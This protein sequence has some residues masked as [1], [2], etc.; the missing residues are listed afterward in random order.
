MEIWLNDK[1]KELKEFTR[2]V[3]LEKILPKRRYYDENEEFPW[4]DD[5]GREKLES[6]KI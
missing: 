1:Q 4:G 3:A 2:K 6:A 5:A